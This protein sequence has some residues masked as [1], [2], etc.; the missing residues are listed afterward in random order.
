MVGGGNPRGTRLSAARCPAP[1][2]ARGT[3]RHTS[4]RARRRRDVGRAGV[5][6][7]PG[8][9]CGKEPILKSGSLQGGKALPS[10]PRH[11][12]QCSLLHLSSPLLQAIKRGSFFYLFLLSSSEPSFPFPLRAPQ[13]KHLPYRCLWC[14]PL[15]GLRFDV[16]QVLKAGLQP[17]LL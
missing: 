13:S 8:K 2:R 5:Q 9:C 4:S 10:L 16:H 17:K 7:Q 14:S 1:R 6:C 11:Y 12:L 15:H 3:A